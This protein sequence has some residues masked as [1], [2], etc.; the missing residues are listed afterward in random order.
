M[1]N[2]K[3]P[4]PHCGEMIWVFYPDY[5]VLKSAEKDHRTLFFESDMDKSKGHCPECKND[6]Y[7]YFYIKRH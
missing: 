3:L 1:P 7:I 2:Q 5:S 6:F 4:C